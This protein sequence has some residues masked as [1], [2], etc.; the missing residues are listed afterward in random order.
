MPRRR[1]GGRRPAPGAMHALIARLYPICRSITGD[2]V[3]E[4][5]RDPAGA[6]CRSR[7]TRSRP[8][9]PSSTGPCRRNGT[10]AT[11]GSTN[12]RG[13]RV[14]DFRA[15]N[16]HVAELQHAGRGHACASPS[17]GRTSTPTRTTPT[18]IPYRTSYYQ[19]RLGF[20]PAAR[21]ARGPARGRLRGGDRR[22][23]RRRRAHLRRML[24]PGRDRADEVLLSTPRLPS[25]ARQRQPLGHRGRDRAGRATAATQPRRLGYRFLFIPGTIGSITWLARNEDAARRASAT[26]W[27]WPASATRAAHYK[28]SRRGDARDRPRRGARAGERAAADT[29]VDFIPYGYDERQ[30]CSPGFDLP[31][32]C[33]IAHALG[34]L[35]G[36]P[37]LGRRPRLR[38]PRGA[39]RLAATLPAAIVDVLERDRRYRNLQPEGRAAA[40]PPR[41]L[42]RDRRRADARA[43]ARWRCSG[44]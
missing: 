19:P 12:S 35:P 7:S 44:C 38:P 23:P 20:L 3:R 30:Y 28:R 11:P 6:G 43:T 13:E 26:G 25:L 31:V 17:C 36:I 4:T 22:H 2:G 18:W 1:G 33:L 42:R 21:A 8:A 40:R 10:S 5:L 41:P 34:Q 29:V 27:C 37:H 32:G 16:L 15:H 9:R 24:R 14:V 39:G